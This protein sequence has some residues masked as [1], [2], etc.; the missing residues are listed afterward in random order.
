VGEARCSA[1]RLRA[2]TLLL[3]AAATRRSCIS[4]TVAAAKAEFISG[5][6]AARLNSAK[7]EKNIVLMSPKIPQLVLL[8]KIR[9]ATLCLRISI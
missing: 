2:A 1:S 7:E 3:P 8:N 5:I 9:P 6:C 4:S